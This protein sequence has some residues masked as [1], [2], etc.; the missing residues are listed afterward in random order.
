[1]YSRPEMLARLTHTERL[2][3]ADGNRFALGQWR[4]RLH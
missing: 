1:M 4:E 2:A 3:E